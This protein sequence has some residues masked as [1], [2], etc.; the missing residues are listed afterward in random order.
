[1]KVTA[2]AGS[3]ANV[4]YDRAAREIIAHAAAASGRARGYCAIA[5]GS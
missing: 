3:D 1:M 5:A 4:D 2:S